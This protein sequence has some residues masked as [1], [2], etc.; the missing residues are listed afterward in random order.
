MC[1]NPYFVLSRLCFVPCGKCLFCRKARGRS[2]LVRCILE[3]NYW[4]FAQFVTL[5][6]DDEH[7]GDSLLHKQHLQL[8]FKR[9]R[10]AGL[11]FS[12]YACGEYG[13]TTYRPHY[14]AIIFSNWYQASEIEKHWQNGNVMVYVA[15]N[16]MM[17]YVCGYVTNKFS[18]GNDTIMS[19]LEREQRQF[20]L[21]S[22]RPALGLRSVNDLVR[23]CNGIDVLDGVR[24][25]G[26]YY[27]LPRYLR[28]KLRKEIFD[29]ADIERLLE[30]RIANY[31]DSLQ[32]KVK[33]W[34]NERGIEMPLG[35]RE[36]Y[37]KFVGQ[38][39]RNARAFHSLKN[40]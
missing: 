35:F 11:K 29:E 20:S 23:Y 38:N 4:A 21:M 16:A 10:K 32:E 34:Y 36:A 7:L 1:E 22:R 15:N 31:K 18:I 2:W 30:A 13:E 5:T 3:S 17:A 26:D 33:E 27:G 37:E 9:M 28:N 24:I 25:A 12:Y 6:Y 39:V 40:R 14:H 8:F 19:M